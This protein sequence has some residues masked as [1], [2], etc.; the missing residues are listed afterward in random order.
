MSGDRSTVSAW[1]VG[2][3]VVAMFFRCLTRR[4]SPSVQLTSFHNSGLLTTPPTQEPALFI[5]L[6]G[7]SDLDVHLY[8]RVICHMLSHQGT[9]NWGLL[10]VGVQCDVA[11][12]ACKAILHPE[13]LA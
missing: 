2:H 13:R 12:L 7:L 3:L 9:D 5:S 8:T 6:Q 1:D 11:S 4:P 10:V